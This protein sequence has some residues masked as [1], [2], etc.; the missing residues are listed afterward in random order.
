MRALEGDRNADCTILVTG[1]AG[2]IGSH[3][4]EKLLETG[5]RVVNIDNINDFYAPEIKRGNLAEIEEFIVDRGINRYRYTFLEGDIRD[6]GFL[7][8]AFERFK[9][10][11]IVHLAAYAGVRPSIQNPGLYMDVNI[12]GTVNLLE[13]AKEYKIR[14]FVFA[15][16]SSVYGNNSKVPFSETDSVDNPISPYAASKKAGELMCHTYHHLYGM[17]IACLRF[18]TVFGP[19]QRPDLAIHKFTRL[20]FEGK[21]IPFY[22]DGTTER[23]YTFI[24]D[25]LD[26]LVKA[27]GWVDNEQHRYGIFNLGESNTISLTRMV[28]ALE[29]ASGIK[30]KLNMLPMQP[31]DVQRTNADITRSKSILGYNP[32]VKFE[33]GISDFMDWYKTKFLD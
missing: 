22:G 20:L 24:T 18:F 27:I 8:D 3:L 23:D 15:S 9:V 17:N 33:D 14:K 16:S 2:F 13:C 28:K 31:G 6:L 26:G 29:T 7:K 4:C 1:G 11:S 25:I 12:N 10:D 21:D 30:A 32:T 5:Y 19:R